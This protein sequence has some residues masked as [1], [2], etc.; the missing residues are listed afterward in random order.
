MKHFPFGLPVSDET[1]QLG[2]DIYACLERHAPQVCLSCKVGCWLP[3]FKHP[4]FAEWLLLP[5]SDT[6][7][8]RIIRN[9]RFDQF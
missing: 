9:N 8:I 5:N 4:E 3:V 2:F 1:A 7:L 6:W